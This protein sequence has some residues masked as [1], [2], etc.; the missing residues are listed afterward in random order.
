MLVKLVG[1]YIRP[2]RWQVLVILLLQIGAQVASLTLPTINADIINK[3]VVALDTGFVKSHSA[4]MLA[5]A[6]GQAVCQVAAIYLAGMTAMGLGR[7][8][9]DTVF[10]RT[11]EFS[12]REVNRFGAPSLITRTTNDV[13]Q[14][15]M[16]VF[17]VLGIIIG[18]PI[19][20]IVGVVMALRADVGLSW[21]IVVAVVLLGGV[22][23]VLMTRLGP[24]FRRQQSRIDDLNRV[25]REQ[26]TGVRVVRA[27]VREPYEAERFDTTNGNL[28][29]I[30][31]SV[32][33]FMAAMF[34]LVMFIMN[35]S[36]IGVFWF[37]SSRIDS[38]ELEVG[39]LTSFTTYLIQILMSVMMAVMMIIFWPRATVCA[40]RILEVLDTE[41]SV[42]PPSH[43]VTETTETGTVA[44]H[45]VEFSYPGA[46]EPVLSGID[47]SMAKGTTT[48]IIGSTG[49]GK[50]T[51]VNLIPRLFDVT[52]GT[53]LVDGV[54]V[55]ALDPHLLERAVGLVPQ[56]PYLFTGTVASNLRD[57][58]PG[59][60]DEDLWKALRIAQADDFVSEM[61]EGLDAPIVQGGTNVS[62][63]QR[64]RLSIAR[65][66]VK[67][68]DVYLFD[69]SFSALDV[70]TD[71]RLRAALD[72]SITDAAIL[73][74]AQRVSTIR[75]ADQILVLDD[76]RLV[77]KGT[78]EELMETCPTY[79]EIVNSQLSAEEA[80]A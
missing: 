27:F 62:G 14:V 71:A 61:P 68:A 34:P 20:M 54:D 59:A 4:L 64:Q 6:A 53:V 70:T 13:Q 45:D 17:F 58:D 15:Q 43:P 66:L 75:N 47:F 44:F 55:R 52:G 23:G 21:I 35:I 31:V 9:R 69:D 76:G 7:D 19:T 46:D 33:R 65:A 32:G 37:A 48:A 2:Y 25:T 29:D 30:Q 36:Q 63:G 74:V 26:I 8:I 78:H 79:L 10:N 57:G 77:G 28:R 38:G 18:A 49:A 1:R 72:E 41:T 67:K 56:K 39:A 51:L 3:G 80:A 50:T 16:L 22:I 5:V 40:T 12:S 60:T 73:M 11:I 24:L 42:T